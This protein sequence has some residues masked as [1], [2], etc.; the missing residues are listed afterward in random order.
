F[1]DA[2]IDYLPAQENELGWPRLVD[3]RGRVSLHRADLSLFAEQALMWPAPQQS[4]QLH[5]VQ[6]RIPDLE[7]NPVLT[8]TGDTSAPASTYLALMTHSPL[9]EM[10]DEQFNE[11]RATGDWQVPL[12]LN[13]P[14][15]HSDDTTVKGTIHF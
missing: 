15:M 14:L 10:L 12:A 1:S 3:M 7:D 9:G 11:S 2:I 4:I 13:I 5:D 6:A 8:I